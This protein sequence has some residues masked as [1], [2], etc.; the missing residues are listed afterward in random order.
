[1]TRR[2]PLRAKKGARRPAG[3]PQAWDN[4]RRTTD[5]TA[6]PRLGRVATDWRGCRSHDRPGCRD[7]RTGWRSGSPWS[8]SAAWGFQPWPGL[9]SSWWRSS[10]AWSWRVF[11]SWF[12][13]GR[14]AS[15]EARGHGTKVWHGSQSLFRPLTRMNPPPIGSVALAGSRAQGLRRPAG[16]L[17]FPHR[18]MPDRERA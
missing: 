15:H 11:S 14:K 6:S 12:G 7:H 5:P 10:W 2:V 16:S 8:P 1:M 9:A 3:D 13:W 4:E 17:R 18:A